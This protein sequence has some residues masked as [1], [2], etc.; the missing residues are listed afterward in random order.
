MFQFLEQKKKQEAEERRAKQKKVVE[1]FRKMLEV[2]LLF[3]FNIYFFVKSYG[4]FLP[5]YSVNF[6]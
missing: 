4:S 3:I 6:L 2:S 1:D 5:K